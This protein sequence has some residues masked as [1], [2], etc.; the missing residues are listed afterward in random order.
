MPELPE[1]ETMRRGVLD[2][3]GARIAKAERTPCHK[4]PIVISPRIDRFNKRVVNREITS[5]DRLGKRVVVRLDSD[6]RLLFEPRM[7]GLVLIADPPTIQHLRFCL[8]LKKS[9]VK[10]LL[11]WD[12]RGLG[13]VTLLSAAQYE[14]KLTDGKLGP[15]ALE[16]SAEDF[17]SRFRHSKREIKVALLDQKAVLG[18]G[19]LYASEI[20]H[21]AGVHP[22]T[23]CDLISKK[24]WRLIYDFMIQVFELAIEYEGSTLSD[25]TYRNAINGEGSYQN[26]HRVYD[27]AGKL[28]PSCRKSSIIRIVQA[29]RATFYCKKCQTKR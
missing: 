26:E 13:N 16:I 15:D 2:I 7:T 18:I 12:R 29:Q 23:R 10:E 4:R 1:V 22:Q 8:H 6:D 17:P 9:R 21:L 25:G 11:F 19:N 3:V 27:R 5:V 14:T 28:C 20:L 24:R